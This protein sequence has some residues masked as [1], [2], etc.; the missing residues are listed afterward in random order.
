MNM[1]IAEMHSPRSD[2]QHPHVVTSLKLHHP[3]TS[4]SGF[5]GGFTALA[6]HS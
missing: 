3:N 5:Y 6:Q 1:Q 2:R 4:L